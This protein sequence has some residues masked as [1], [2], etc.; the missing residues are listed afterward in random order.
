MKSL[1]RTTLFLALTFGISFTLAIAYKLF[2]GPG[3]NTP[4]FMLVGVIYMLI[5]AFS[6]II[7]RSLIHRERFT[8]GLLVSFRVNRWFFAAWLLMP[9]VVFATIGINI[10]FPGVEYNH[11]M[12]GFF[13]RLGGTVP[14]EDLESM[15]QAMNELP[16]NVMWI[17]LL[18]GLVAG[19][20]VN[21]LAAFGEELGWRGF[22]LQAFKEMKFFK[23]AIVIGFI[24]GVWHAPL[25]LMG[26]NYPQHPQIGVLMMIALC[27]LLTPFHLY[28][29]IKAKSVIAASIMHGTLNATAGISIMAVTGGNDLTSGIAGLAGFIA[30]AIFLVLLFMFDYFVSKDRMLI[31]PISKFL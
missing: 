12:T 7:V 20:T 6:V 14:S 27:I 29:T 19:I 21:A 28:V 2:G 25:I 8:N 22:L 11:G 16:I 30:L 17:T 26:H 23:A 18:Q 15:R 4:A 24:W 1:N 9:L 10:M 5:P 3:P 13:E 31:N